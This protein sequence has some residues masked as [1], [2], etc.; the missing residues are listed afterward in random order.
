MANDVTIKLTEWEI[1]NAILPPVTTLTLYDVKPDL[2]VLTKRVQ[3]IIEKNPWVCS[4]VVKEK[5]SAQTLN[6]AADIDAAKV[7]EDHISQSETSLSLDLSYNELAN[8]LDP[9]LCIRSKEVV[10]KDGLLF[11]VT[12]IPVTKGSASLGTVLE[13][14]GYGLVVSMNHTIGD[15][16]TYYQL[17]QMLSDGAEI[18][19]LNPVRREGFEEAKRAV[20]G[21]AEEK[22]QSSAGLVVNI[23]GKYFG[24][25]LFKKPPQ[26][27][28][29]NQID[30][31]WIEKQK[32][33][34]KAEETVPFISGNDALTSWF[35]SEMKTGFNLMLANLRGRTATLPELC[36]SD[37][38]N[39]EANVPYFPEDVTTASLIRKSITPV[40]GVFRAK[41]AAE[42]ATAIPGFWKM[43]KQD[44]SL[45][46]N[47]AT[48]YTDL[49]VKAG[50][51]TVQPKLHLPIMRPDGLITTIWNSCIVFAPRAGELATLI[52]TRNLDADA[53]EESRKAGV[54]TPLGKRIV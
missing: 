12:I 42:P 47:W 18:E 9:Y 14:D 37:V 44:T 46:T 30:S 4:R 7:A 32:E 22:M 15:G 36:S 33:V 3:L 54:S 13:N 39:Y 23:L 17:Y 5:G 2:E 40:D 53:V 50:E 41:R 27:L 21:D 28:L 16:H 10:N 34:A 38:G 45:I 49:V 6:Y 19:A 48:F 31:A 26:N 25:K 1:R 8:A 20:T 35:F 29:I 52:F 24:A 11:K 43:V 51:A